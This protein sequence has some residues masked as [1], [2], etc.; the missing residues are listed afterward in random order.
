MINFKIEVGKPKKDGSRKIYIRV[1]KNGEYKRIPF[2]MMAGISQ[3]TDRGEITDQMLDFALNQKI[4]EYKGIILYDN[5]PD[6]WSAEEIANYL[7]NHT[8]EA[9]ADKEKKDDEF[10]LDFIAFGR[11]HIAKLK[12][13]DRMKTAEGYNSALNNFCKFLKRDSID[14]NQINKAMLLEYKDWFE[15]EGF[16]NRAWEMYMS[17]LKTLHNNA[18]LLYN[19]EDDEKLNIKL[20]P[21]KTIQFRRSAVEKRDVEPMAL[22][23]TALRYLWDVPMEGLTPRGKM[24]RDAFFLSFSLC[25]MNAVD[26]WKHKQAED[27]KAD[28]IEY[29]R[30]KTA[31]RSGKGAFTRVH[32]NKYIREV[33]DR[34]RGKRHTWF[35][36]ELYSTSNNFNAALS[37]GLADL[38]N[39]A[40]TYYG[41][42][43]NLDPGTKRKQILKRLELPTER[44]L[45]FYA[46]R[47][48]FSTI[49]GNDCHVPTEIID[50]CLCHVVKSVAAEHYIKKDYRYTDETVAKVLDF[51]FCQ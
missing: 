11:E 44:N 2:M 30:S 8:H 6:R 20:S 22:S 26:M 38:V 47:D 43:W 46:A 24:A 36:A 48:S 12:A 50:R 1:I 7:V 13:A 10:K 3:V 9:E 29:Y 31:R 45:I 14:I 32:I 23:A 49:A 37:Y 15:R 18:K 33:H 34:N 17:N 39:N 42:Q 5:V 35:Y 41:M 21:F 28:C 4:N 51:V 16:G 27:C 25:G 40:V 19:D